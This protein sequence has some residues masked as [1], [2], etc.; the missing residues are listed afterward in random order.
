MHRYPD[1][2]LMH[3]RIDPGPESIRILRLA[4]FAMDSQVL[5]SPEEA[6]VEELSPLSDSGVALA[7]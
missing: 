7:G 2:S 4:C 6:P 1:A 3:Q 5:P